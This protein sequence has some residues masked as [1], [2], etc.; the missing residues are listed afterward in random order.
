[1]GAIRLIFR[2]PFLLLH[3]VLGTPATALAFYPPFRGRRLKGELLQNI[4]LRWWGRTTCRI[5]G[6]TVHC[7]KEFPAGAQLLVANHISWLDIQV[8][9]SLSPMG[10]VAKAEIENWPVAGLMARIG[11]TVFHRRG[12]HDSASG[13]ATVM[14]QRLSQGGKVTIF[15]E[16]GIL[17]GFGVK[18]FY[19]RLFAAAIQTGTPV[20]PVAIRYLLD[21]QHFKD[22]TFRDDENFVTNIFRL[23]TQPRRIVEVVILEPLVSQDMARRD[24]AMQ[25]ESAV[26]AAFDAEITSPNE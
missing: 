24:L 12:S 10:F 13:V 15:P 26:R 4:M 21:G 16:G 14:A 2:L 9:F 3:L 19:A 18:R 22:I 20:Q 7:S 8:L 11:G 5:F 25:A 17:P 23:L 6:V 1:M